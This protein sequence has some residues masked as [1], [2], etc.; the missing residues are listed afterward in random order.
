MFWWTPSQIE[1]L[2][3]KLEE[4]GHIFGHPQGHVHHKDEDDDQNEDDAHT[5]DHLQNNQ[6]EGP[7]QENGMRLERSADIPLH[8]APD[9]CPGTQ[10]ERAG[11]ASA[12]EGCPNQS[13]C[14]SGTQGDAVDPGVEEVRTKLKDIKSKVLV[15]SGK[16]GVGKS[17]LC[18]QLAWV[19]QR[20]QY[21]VGLL[22]VDICGP[23]IPRM[24][25]TM[26]E[27][28]HQ[29]AD[30]WS[31]I[32]VEENLAIM[33]IGF[34]LPNPD[35]AIIWRG[36]KKNALIK[37][38]LSDVVWGE[39]D[40]LLVDTPPGT[41]D[42]HLSL[43]TYLQGAGISGAVVVT[44]PQEVALQDVRKEINFCK[45]VGIRVLGV[46]ENM[47]GS[48]FNSSESA[49]VKAMCEK[50]EVPF[51]GALTLR[52]EV[53]RAC[54]LGKAVSDI[55]PDTSAVAELDAIT[56]KLFGDAAAKGKMTADSGGET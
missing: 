21:D 49:G 10:S 35:D 37:Q 38:F 47:S 28:V 32:Y 40:F 56:D 3:R 12:C 2:S 20:R 43:V 25:G 9:E 41:S 4:S 44:T 17:T 33:S 52:P 31:P 36:P 45:K 15:L 13:I 16:G 29:S 53:L 7:P 39:Q 8:A 19:L 24:T 42:E 55:D 48:V 5:D 18:S 6:D 23:S 11:K 27:G 30:G 1:I 46:V 50:M 26:E 22:D 51:A 54:E 14:A 34:L